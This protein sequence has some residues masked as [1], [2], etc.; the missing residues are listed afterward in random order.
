M[1]RTTV[2][3]HWREEALEEFVGHLHSRGFRV[4]EARKKVFAAVLARDDHFSADELAATLARGEG[5]VSRGTVY[6]SLDL[7]L[8]TGFVRKIVDSEAHAH[9]EHI[10]KRPRHEHL[11]CEVCGAYIEVGGEAFGELIDDLCRR[12]DFEQR[13]WR[14]LVLGRCSRCRRG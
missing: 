13:A 14:V 12:H 8:E 7:L 9:Y 6:R 2:N 5:R 10:F 1:S 3:G 11:K 4:T